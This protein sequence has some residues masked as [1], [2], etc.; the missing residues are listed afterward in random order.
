[1]LERMH[2]AEL[3]E[4]CVAMQAFGHRIGFPESAAGMI[5]WLGTEINTLG[6]RGC[7]PFMA[8]DGLLI[9]G[10]R[11]LQLAAPLSQSSQAEHAPDRHRVTSSHDGM[12]VLIWHGR[13][14]SFSIFERLEMRLM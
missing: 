8:G 10:L 4:S 11:L 6:L 2:V 12:T 13:N 1:M 5:I 7:H 3:L 14:V 9:V